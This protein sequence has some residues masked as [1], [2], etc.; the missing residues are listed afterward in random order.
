MLLRK[1]QGNCSV[2]PYV[3]EHDGAVVE[4]P[5]WLGEDL[6]SIKG[7]DYTVVDE[8]PEPA[9]PVGNPLEGDGVPA[10]TATKILDWVGDDKDRAAAALDAERAK[11]EGARSSLVAKLEKL[12]A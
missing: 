1:T 6:L 2:G 10:G 9:E 7:H 5:D 3:W 12:A 11:G 8:A 4:V